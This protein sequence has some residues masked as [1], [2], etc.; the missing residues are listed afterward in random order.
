MYTLTF[1]IA[2]CVSVTTFV[3]TVTVTEARVSPRYAE[4]AETVAKSD[5]VVVSLVDIW[6]TR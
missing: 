4:A 2:A 1:V 5:S 6:G 3:A